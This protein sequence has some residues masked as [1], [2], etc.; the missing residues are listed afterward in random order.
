[1]SLALLIGS[2]TFAADKTSDMPDW[3]RGNYDDIYRQTIVTSA[4]ACQELCRKD[5]ARCRGSLVLQADITKPE[6]ICT[7]HDGSG[8]HPAFPSHP[9]EALDL[10]VALRDLNAYRARFGLPALHLEARLIRASQLHAQDMADHAHLSHYGADGS[11]PAQRVVRQ[12]Y[13]FSVTGEN[14]ASGQKSWTG[15]F[16]G[17][18]NSPH[19]NENLLLPEA[20]DFG[21]ALVYAPETPAQTYW[22]MIVAAPFSP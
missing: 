3:Y 11:T 20:R 21:L 15:V 14:I 7:L 10:A 9:P 2:P 5:G 22:A 1:M 4:V 13:K 16:R 17:W 8:A 19:H 6:R 12:G 18:Q